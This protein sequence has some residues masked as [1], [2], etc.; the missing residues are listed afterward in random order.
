MVDVCNR[1]REQGNILRG[2]QSSRRSDH[3]MDICKLS[4]LAEGVML[5]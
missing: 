4:T 2:L 3:E 1:W 5:K